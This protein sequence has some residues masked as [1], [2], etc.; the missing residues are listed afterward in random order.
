MQEGTNRDARWRRALLAAADEDD[1]AAPHDATC[2]PSREPDG[3]A[4]LVSDD[5]DREELNYFKQ[6]KALKDSQVTAH[7]SRQHVANHA[8]ALALNMA[9]K[10]GM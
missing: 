4:P 1:D 2:D 7:I 3:Q 10:K 8:N 5:E 9:H 6:Q